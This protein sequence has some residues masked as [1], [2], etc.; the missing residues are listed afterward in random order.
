MKS[1]KRPTHEKDLTT[2]A[3]A[4]KK[5][6]R[7]ALEAM[8][9]EHLVEDPMLNDPSL[10]ISLFEDLPWKDPSPSGEFEAITS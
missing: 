3:L 8:I 9:A 7:H 5:R 10:E 4:S 6:V 2:E 1:N